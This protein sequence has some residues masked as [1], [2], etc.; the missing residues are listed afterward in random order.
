MS[1]QQ[2]NLL[3]AIQAAPDFDLLDIRRSDDY[4]PE[5]SVVLDTDVVTRSEFSPSQLP[6]PSSGP[7]ECSHTP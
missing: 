3:T 6:S 5:V 2:D 4:G 1:G 7:T